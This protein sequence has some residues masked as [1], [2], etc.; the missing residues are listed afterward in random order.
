M[1][2]SLSLTRWVRTIIFSLLVVFAAFLGVTSNA[3]AEELANPKQPFGVSIDLSD[4]AKHDDPVNPLPFDP[5]IIDALSSAG[6]LIQR[7]RLALDKAGSIASLGSSLT[8]G[9]PNPNSD[10]RAEK[11]NT[12]AG[13]VAAAFFSSL[14]IPA[15]GLVFGGGAGAATGG[16]LGGVVGGVAGLANPLAPVIGGIPGAIV[17]AL[18]GGAIGIPI[19]AV[20][21]ALG[22]GF[23]GWGA[24]A[25]V[26]GTIGL[27][28]GAA[29]GSLVTDVIGGI[30]GGIGG[31][32]PGAFLGALV[33]VGV[34][35]VL[36]VVAGI[37][38]ATLLTAGIIGVTAVAALALMAGSVVVA[39]A[40]AFWPAVIVGVVVGISVWSISGS[41]WLV[42]TFL[43]GLPTAIAGFIAFLGAAATAIAGA[44][45]AVSGAATVVG[46]SVAGVAAALTA[47]GVPTV[48]ISIV[49]A[50]ITAA[51]GALGVVAAALTA[52]AG[53]ATVAAG[54]VS[55]VAVAL[56]GFGALVVS[57]FAMIELIFTI[58][59][60]VMAVGAF[61][62]V[63]FM[64]TAALSGIVVVG[65]GCIGAA[66]LAFALLAWPLEVVFL[67][68]VTFLLSVFVG[69]PLIALAGGVI[70]AT[71]GSGV[72]ILLALPFKLATVPLGAGIGA[73]LGIANPLNFV[74]GFITAIPGAI[75][76]ALV[77]PW[78][79]GPTAAVLGFFG[80]DFLVRLI[81]A[82]ALGTVGALGVGFI[83]AVVGAGA[84]VIASSPLWLLTFIA[85]LIVRM[86]RHNPDT[87]RKNPELANML[88]AAATFGPPGAM[89]GWI[90]GMLVGAGA[91]FITPTNI[92]AAIPAAILGV[93]IGGSTGGLLGGIVGALG[94]A[95][96]TW[97][98]LSTISGTLGAVLGL[99]L[100]VLAAFPASAFAGSL[101]G[102][103]VGSAGAWILS[104]V[105][106]L[107]L[108]PGLFGVLLLFGPLLWFGLWT[109]LFLLPALFAVAA[110]GFAVIAVAFFWSLLA[111]TVITLP[112]AGVA[113]MIGGG[114]LAVIVATTL[115]ALPIWG[116]GIIP[117]VFLAV[118]AVFAIVA[119]WS[120]IGL[121]VGITVGGTFLLA[122]GV[123]AICF[124]VLPA[125]IFG[126]W[127]IAG[128]V[129]AIPGSWT[130]ALALSILVTAGAKIV[131]TIIMMPIG[132]IGGFLLGGVAGFFLSPLLMPF[133]GAF[134]AFLG[135][136]IGIFTPLNLFGTIPGAMIGAVSLSL[137]SAL[138]GAIGG[139]VIGTSLTWILG[140][141]IGLPVAVVVG[142]IFGAGIGGWVATLVGLGAGSQLPERKKTPAGE[143]EPAAKEPVLESTPIRG[144]KAKE[145]EVHTIGR[146]SSGGSSR[147]QRQAS[148]RTVQSMSEEMELM[149]A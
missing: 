41:I 80:G 12:K 49:S 17:G 44:G 147:A 111:A 103:L 73:V 137:L 40:I 63:W 1:N 18:T 135:A 114:L 74:F 22:T 14:L 51:G 11:K 69:I 59:S 126:I 146:G 29:I 98:G 96:F 106:P 131:L 129:F 67:T 139:G 34:S 94:G 105:I 123:G 148:S 46:G 128:V 118:L 72:G 130:L 116:L 84:G 71:I 83:G 33:G 7:D 60:V 26:N 30:L 37:I 92:L 75:F 77:G 5:W 90:L 38:G 81:G 54:A 13:E 109:A 19:G 112:L 89:I 122:L 2:R 101:V 138:I 145:P 124:L 64:L 127:F 62:I 6:V 104:S 48:V 107:V 120:L 16:L 53:V 57:S 99:L 45:T 47:A 50:V 27:L 4:L 15:A 3:H 88:D 66:I 143:P 95:F 102:A 76:G 24:G 134:G 93:V 52:L 9:E 119:F 125:F 132:I 82:L 91:A 100:G 58:A 110:T 43:V 113:L 8:K 86:T 21:G 65:V 25:I 142:G 55:V 61:V 140:T 28:A 39:A 56:A 36:P 136:M 108:G 117:L 79:F 115:I 10:N 68:V 78:I 133:T 97:L 87:V 149:A 70:G 31:F 42:A 144:P 23:L 20:I 32:F 121:W 35:I 85:A 141:V